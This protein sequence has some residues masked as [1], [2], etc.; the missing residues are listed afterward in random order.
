MV[1][2]FLFL[3]IICVYKL[4]LQLGSGSNSYD[5]LYPEI[6][7][8]I[9]GIFILIL[10]F[11]HISQYIRPN[12]SD[13]IFNTLYY[14]INF[15]FIGQS[16]TVLFL[17]YSGFGVMYLAMNKGDIYIKSIPKNRFLKTLLHFDIS[18]I[19]YL[20][21]GLIF[22]EKYG[23]LQII[24][25]LIGWDAV[26]NYNWYIFVILVL[27]LISYVSLS[28]C[29]SSNINAKFCGREGKIKNKSIYAVLICFI[30]TFILIIFLHQTKS[31]FWWDTV[32]CYPLG[33][34]YYTYR[35]KIDKIFSKNYKLYLSLIIVLF[36][37]H[38][39]F[40]LLKTNEVLLVFKHISFLFIVILITMKIKISN[41]ILNF[42]GKHLFSIF[43]L[44]RLPMIILSHFGVENK[45]MLF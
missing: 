9:K 13:S 30:L 37:L 32:I 4:K 39:A 11:S 15:V 12:L 21:L 40:T 14:Y 43:M 38:I 22:G 42:C 2:I 19:I 8:S 31:I 28:I 6:T 18:V 25:S 33:M 1:F 34:L 24:L 17:F 16:A 26:G 3:S 7:T 27:Y 45:P 29:T 41:F 44:Q 23:L 36:L 5:Y 10:L 20:L 35:D